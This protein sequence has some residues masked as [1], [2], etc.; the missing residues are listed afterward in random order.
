MNELLTKE[1][2]KEKY[3][4]FGRWYDVGDSILSLFIGRLRKRLI[5]Y[6]YGNVL[7]IG[8][9]TGSNLKYYSRDC[10]VTGIDMS[11]GMLVHARK[12]A[13][14]HGMK[15]RFVEGDATQLPF[16]SKRFDCVVD[17]LGFCTYEPPLRVLRE[18]KRVCKK[19]GKLLLLEHGLS[20][21]SVI[22]RLQR[23]SEPKHYQKIGCHL[24]RDHE[25]FIRKAGLRIVHSERKW[26]G[27]FYLIVVEV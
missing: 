6:A 8:V 24:L 9:G 27:I 3:N 23:R 26:F 20:K 12:K 16:K 13:A 25:L 1:E 14:K 15:I 17:T 21:S 4:Q 5:S 11:K 22:Q 2:V 7:E 18:M 10:K 19:G